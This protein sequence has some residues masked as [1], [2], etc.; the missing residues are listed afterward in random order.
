VYLYSGEQFDPDLHLYYNRARYLNVS[1][2]RFWTMDSYEGDPQAPAS[3]H[4]YLYAEVDVVNRTDPSGL[5]DIL[6]AVV[7]TAIISGVSSLTVF[8]ITGS[9]RAALAGG[10]GAGVVSLAILSGQPTFIRNTI[11]S[12]LA[13]AVFQVIANQYEIQY[14]GK[15]ISS[16][17]YF[18]SVVEA[19]GAGSVNGFVS[20]IFPFGADSGNLAAGVYTVT[21]SILTNIA[22]G[23]AWYDGLSVALAIAGLNGIARFN[24]TGKIPDAALEQI[25][26]TTVVKTIS[27][28]LK[29]IAK[30]FIKSVDPSL[31]ASIFAQ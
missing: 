30:E 3:L 1:T 22:Q 17:L 31:A 10:A 15:S 8:A 16:S 13:N 2:G 18:Q 12:G 21:N 29:P 14:L 23:K 25:I 27:T 28:A 19:F 20:A 7:T 9:F 4:R 6:D 11:I 5:V 26:R 24:L